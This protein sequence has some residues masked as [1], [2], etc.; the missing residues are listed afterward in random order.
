M[1]GDEMLNGSLPGGGGLGGIGT[2]GF[3]TGGKS[4]YYHGGGVSRSD[5]FGAREAK[6]PNK[7]GDW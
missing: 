7:T 4:R 3:L 2:F 1:M 5:D 6:G